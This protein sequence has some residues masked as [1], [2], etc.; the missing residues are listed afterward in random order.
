MELLTKPEFF[1]VFL[2]FRFACN[3]VYNDLKV[4]LNGPSGI[5]ELYAYCEGWVLVIALI[6]FIYTSFT[7]YR[8][9]KN[10]TEK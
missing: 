10:N 7:K 5:T 4:V 1:I 3:I 8:S 9:Q 2:L 6:A